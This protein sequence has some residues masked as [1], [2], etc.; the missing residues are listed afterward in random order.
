MGVNRLHIFLPAGAD[1][2][3]PNPKTAEERRRRLLRSLSKLAG[4]ARHFGSNVLF[5]HYDLL[6]SG[7]R[8]PER[9]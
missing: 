9:L 5:L 4:I 2:G 6:I 1:R 3:V 8:I 7:C